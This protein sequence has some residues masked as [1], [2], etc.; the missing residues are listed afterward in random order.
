MLQSL[1]DWGS[2]PGSI[3]YYLGVLC[4][5]AQSCPTLGNH[6]DCSPSDSSVHGDSPEY[7]TGLLCSPP[8][9]LPN[10]GIEPRSPALQADS[11]PAEVEG[12]PKSKS[13]INASAVLKQD[14]QWIERS[15]II[16]DFPCFIFL[17]RICTF[18]LGC[19]RSLE[20]MAA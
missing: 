1:R 7:W 9:D 3:I 20:A 2:N 15:V 12:K 5:V 17:S 14:F 4:L 11:L 18:W 19:Q 10:S 13:V 16:D 6:M 8:G